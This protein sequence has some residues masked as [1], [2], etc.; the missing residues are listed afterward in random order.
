MVEI[1]CIMCRRMHQVT[2]NLFFKIS[3]VVISFT[4]VSPVPWSW[5]VVMLSSVDSSYGDQ[6]IQL[7]KCTF[8]VFSVGIIP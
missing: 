8:A 3:V 4:K 2:Q 1:I 6:S 5:S 7:Q